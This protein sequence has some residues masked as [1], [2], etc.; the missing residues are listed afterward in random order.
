MLIHKILN[1]TYEDE[2]VSMFTSVFTTSEGD[3]EGKLIGNLA[4][5]LSSMI[6]NQDV[7]CIGTFEDGH[8]IGSIF[9]TRLS[10]PENMQVYMLAP[11]AVST[12]H[13]RKDVGRA[14]VTYGLNE[15]IRRNVDVVITYGDPGFYSKINFKPLSEAVIKAPFK[16]SM[17]EGWLGQSLTEDPIPMISQRPSCVKAFNNPA[18][19]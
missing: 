6:D 19:W 10:F 3:K 8:L 15:L 11:V 2:V 14:L 5:E 17:P 18:Y 7:I 9:L 16:L 12:R 4:S 1:Q 13:Q